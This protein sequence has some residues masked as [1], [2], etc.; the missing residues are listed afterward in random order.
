M[1]VVTEHAQVIFRVRWMQ[2]RFP[3]KIGDICIMKSSLSFVGS[4]NHLLK[5]IFN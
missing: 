5:L 1:P 4:F 2:H 3:F